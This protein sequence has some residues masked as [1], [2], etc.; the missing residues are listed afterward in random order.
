MPERKKLELQLNKTEILELL[1]D[2]P[3]V[4]Q[5]RFGEYYLYSVKDRKGEEYSFFAPDELHEKMKQLH[6]GNKVEVT[7]LA[8]QNG[9]KILTKYDLKLV[10]NGT[11]PT[12]P[13]DNKEPKS[14]GNNGSKDTY[15]EAML[16]SYEDAI[17]IQEKLNGMVDVN[18]IAIT[19]FIARSKINGNGYN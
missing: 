15:F 14:N 5:S 12:Q 3:V 4:G 8:E 11:Q 19:L 7:K 10:R 1:F 13:A 6:K 18:R 9:K 16:S 2:E 17:K